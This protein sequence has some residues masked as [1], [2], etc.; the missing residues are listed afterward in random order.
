MYTNYKIKYIKKPFKPILNL[1]LKPGHTH[2]LH[3]RESFD[4]CDSTELDRKRGAAVPAPAA[5]AA[6]I[7]DV[8]CE[9]LRIVAE[10]T[11]RGLAP[12]PNSP[13]CWVRDHGALRVLRG[14]SGALLWRPLA[15]CGS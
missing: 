3:D 10:R 13:F 1:N 15:A 2:F 9:L 8:D 11:E 14:E 7:A 4:D 5:A 6:D 12:A